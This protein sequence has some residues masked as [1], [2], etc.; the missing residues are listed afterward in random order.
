MESLGGLVAREG[1]AL[2][3]SRI[4]VQGEVQVARGVGQGGDPAES[5]SLA[6]L[7]FAWQAV[8]SGE[9]GGF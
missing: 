5:A 6:H 2:L 9:G 4:V 7:A 8:Q 3:L 1:L